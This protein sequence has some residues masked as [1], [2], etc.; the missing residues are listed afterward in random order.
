MK[1]HRRAVFLV[2]FMGSGKTTI[3]SALAHRLGWRFVDLDSQIE[4]R[5]KQAIPELFRERG[6]S[7][8]REAETSALIALL[9]ALGDGDP[10]V[11]ALG[12]GAFAQAGNREMLE[13]F[14]APTIFLEAPVEELF[15]RCCAGGVDRPLFRDEAQFRRLYEERIP[16]Y[17][18]ARFRIKTDGKSVGE[19]IREIESMVEHG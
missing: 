8:F 9:K 16:S 4:A 6:E 1:E 11:V 2:G 17:T 12:G 19:V 5:E 3:G 10:T 14:G 7:G 15:K 13:V 18:R